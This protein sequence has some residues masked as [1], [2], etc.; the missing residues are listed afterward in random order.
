MIDVSN[1]KSLEKKDFDIGSIYVA[2]QYV[3]TN[4]FEGVDINYTNFEDV[5]NFIKSYFKGRSF[6]Y[7][8]NRE[9]SYSIN[10]N[11]ADIFNNSFAN[12][13]AYAVVAH[14]PLTEM[15]FEIEEHFFTFNRKSF[16]NLDDAI[17]WVENTLSSL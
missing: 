7:I 8:A 12:L 3:I 11:D 17:N 1:L 5:G 14:N 6:G 13:K 10:L 4:F 16:R 9:N 15:V 2:N